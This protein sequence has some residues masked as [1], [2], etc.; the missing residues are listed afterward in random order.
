MQILASALKAGY[1]VENAVRE[2][3]KDLRPLYPKDSRIRREFI[4]MIHELDMN[5]TAEQVLKDMAGRIQQEDVDNFVT[6]FAT[7]KRT[8]SMSSCLSSMRADS[9]RETA[10]NPWTVLLP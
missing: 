3:E 4:R 6:V 5:L 2:T 1:S 9:I 7:A 8:G 10:G